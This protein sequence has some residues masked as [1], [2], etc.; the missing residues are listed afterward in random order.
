MQ[1]KLGELCHLMRQLAG[2]GWGSR[3]LAQGGGSLT[4]LL[5]NAVFSPQPPRGL[6]SG[7]GVSGGRGCA[8]RRLSFHKSPQASPH[9][10]QLPNQVANSPKKEDASWCLGRI[11][12]ARSPGVAANPPSLLLRLRL[13]RRGE[14]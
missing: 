5:S 10:R 11:T 3:P 6:E 13:G 7:K 1:M 12:E 14:L 4:D 8:E 2:P 9:P